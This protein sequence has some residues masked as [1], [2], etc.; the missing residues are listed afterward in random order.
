ML[1]SVHSSY[2]KRARLALIA[3]AVCGAGGCQSLHD[4]G[5]PGMASFLNT[6][7]QAQEEERHRTAYQ[8]SR[9]SSELRWLLRN[10]VHSGMS[11]SEVSKIVGDE[12]ERVHDDGWIKN[13]GGFYHA[14]DEVWKWGPDRE[15]NS[16][17][18]VFRDKQLLNFDPTEFEDDSEF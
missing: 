5:V 18:F 12:G 7:A 10:K 2:L 8:K 11:P 9:T 3:L 16:V 13:E 17:M 4:A 1:A 6:E 14:T 15:G